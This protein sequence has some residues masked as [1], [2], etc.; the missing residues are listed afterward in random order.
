MFALNLADMLDRGM[1]FAE[2]DKSDDFM[3]MEKSRLFRIK[4]AIWQQL[5]TVL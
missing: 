3:L 1:T 5:A 2:A 4:E